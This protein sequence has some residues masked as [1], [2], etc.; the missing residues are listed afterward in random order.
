MKKQFAF[1]ASV[2]AL[3][4][5]PAL[6]DTHDQDAAEHDFPVEMEAFMDAYPE[7]TPET[8]FLIDTDG[9]GEV[10]EEEYEAAVDA[11]LITS[12]EPME[13]D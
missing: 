4:A 13:A 12:A 9:D 5:I 6:A 10:S 3:A 11:G 2:I 7:V 1:A 8:F